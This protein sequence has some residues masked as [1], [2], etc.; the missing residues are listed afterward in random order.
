[1]F[2][3]Y[4]KEEGIEY[5]RVVEQVEKN[6]EQYP[7]YVNSNDS[8]R[9][10]YTDYAFCIPTRIRVWSRKSAILICGFAEQHPQFVFRLLE[11]LTLVG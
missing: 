3:L 10:D 2:G 5:P 4:A 11:S 7:L 1:L 9:A 8:L 6:P